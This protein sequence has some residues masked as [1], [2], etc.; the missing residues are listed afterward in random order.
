MWLSYSTF[1]AGFVLARRQGLWSLL[2]EH[3]K[4]EMYLGLVQVLCTHAVAPLL[5][6]KR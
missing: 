6:M 2:S 5:L 1:T 3:V 4:V